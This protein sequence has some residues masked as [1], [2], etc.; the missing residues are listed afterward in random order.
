MVGMLIGFYRINKKWEPENKMRKPIPGYPD[1]YADGQ[2]NIWSYKPTS[3]NSKKYKWKKLKVRIDRDGY[4]RLS[5]SINSKD[6]HLR[7]HRLIAAAWYGWQNGKEINHKDH[8]K[9]NNRPE[10]LEWITRK[11]NEKYKRLAGRQGDDAGISK[12]NPVLVREIRENKNNLTIA[13]LASAYSV[14]VT[15][16]KNVRAYRTWK[17]V[18]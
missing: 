10:N 16:I 1:Y 2:G 13:G 7:V 14:C 11:E 5:L 18:V 15:T 17:E 8:N 9:Q 6:I 4:L 12:L 3:W